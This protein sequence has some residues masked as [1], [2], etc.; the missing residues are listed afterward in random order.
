MKLQC[1]SQCGKGMQQRRVVCQGADGR[2][3]SD[4]ACSSL[5]RPDAS[6]V[7]DMGSCSQN[8]WFFTEWTGQVNSFFKLIPNN[9][10]S[11]KYYHG[12]HQWGEQGSP[13]AIKYFR[14]YSKKLAGWLSGQRCELASEVTRVRFQL[15]AKLF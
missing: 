15:K 3:V 5:P 7:C 1:T 11:F 14:N 6:I 9:S 10:I 12:R 8:T 4:A 13:V 2:D